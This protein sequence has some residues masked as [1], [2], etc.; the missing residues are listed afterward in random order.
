MSD[1]RL[2]PTV[3]YVWDQVTVNYARVGQAY[4]EY[5]N[6]HYTITHSMVSNL[7]VFT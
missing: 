6:K 3:A 4:V 5:D 7:Y 2:G 1:P